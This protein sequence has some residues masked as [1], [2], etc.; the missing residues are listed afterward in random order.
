MTTN[1]D[2]ELTPTERLLGTGESSEPRSG[3]RW[4]AVGLAVAAVVAVGALAFLGGRL[5]APAAAATDTSG[6]TGP[7]GGF[8]PPEGFEP[9]AG[10]GF[11]GGNPG[12]SLGGGAGLSVE[13]TITQVDS[14]TI[15]VELEN[16]QTVTVTIGD[17]TSVSHEE[18]A[19]RDDLAAGTTV[20]VQVDA[21]GLVDG[22]E[23]LE[24]GSVTIV[25]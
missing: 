13:G 1:P 11:P 9:P 4:A 8:Q 12:G 24:A 18:P 5:T 14:D 3:R 25:D 22:G 15:T 10:G 20:R 2:N 7:N 23:D 6:F 16:G 17:E 19:D 21:Q